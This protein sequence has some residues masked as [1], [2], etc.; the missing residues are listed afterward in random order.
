MTPRSERHHQVP[1]WL[2]RHFSWKNR[3]S[4]LLWVGS[5]DTREI[6]Q[7]SVNKTF[8]RNNANTRTDF[9]SQEDGNF[10]PIKSDL[11][12]KILAEFDSLAAP[13]ARRLIGYSRIRRDG[14]PVAPQL[15][16]M[17]LEICKQTIVVQA[18]RSWESQN[19]AGM[20]QDKSELY[21]DLY[22]KSAE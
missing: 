11:G 1:I 19:R 6:R 20:S 2:L 21:L 4:K 7:S 9:Q 17:D 22:F 8:F 14:G 15:S 5:K 10:Q 16:A 13:A 3:G 18:R 12:E